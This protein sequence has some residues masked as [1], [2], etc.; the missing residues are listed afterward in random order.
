MFKWFLAGFQLGVRGILG[1]PRKKSL[2]YL[3]LGSNCGRLDIWTLL[4]PFS[5]EHFLQIG[6]PRRALI[7]ML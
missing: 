2:E 3:L 6:T 7:K 4:S 5:K 1:S